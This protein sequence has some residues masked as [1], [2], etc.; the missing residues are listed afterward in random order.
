MSEKMIQP[1]RGTHDLLGEDYRKHQ[2]IRDIAYTVAQKYGYEPIATPVIEYS[3]VFKRT[4]GETTDI[5]GKEMY[6]FE[7]RG[8]E[9]LTI[10]GRHGQRSAGCYF[11]Q[12]YPIYALKADL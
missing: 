3:S 12:P 11:Q 8:G 4:L 6:T 7:D 10:P 2:W 9:S 5:V 1:V